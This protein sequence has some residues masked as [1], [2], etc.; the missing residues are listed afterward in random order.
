MSQE[1]VDRVT[2]WADAFNRR[3]WDAFAAFMDED[4]ELESR[5]VA[6]EGPYRGHEGLTQ[7]W[8]DFLGA[9]PDYTIEIQELRVLG[10]VTLVHVRG[11]GH[12]ADS[13]APLIDP[14]WLAARWRDGKVVWRRNCAT[15]EEA[16]QAIGL[17]D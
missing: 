10:D 15:E 12:G 1:I 16:L 6:M 7:W 8:H 17:R 14:F 9:F 11:Q 2:E 5:L 13:A 3:D 4:V